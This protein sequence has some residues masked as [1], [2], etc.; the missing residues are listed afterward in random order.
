MFK[1]ISLDLWSQFCA[2]RKK[3][4]RVAVF[5]RGGNKTEVSS[6]EMTPYSTYLLTTCSRVLLD[7]LANRFSF[8][9]EIPRIL[10]NPEGSLPRLNV[11]SICPYPE[12]DQFRPF[13][14]I[15]LP[16]SLS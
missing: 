7:K 5:A 14:S 13:P 11:P 2:S 12:P 6:Q 16:E 3:I 9:Q 10:W 1:M 8:S 4:K 15:P